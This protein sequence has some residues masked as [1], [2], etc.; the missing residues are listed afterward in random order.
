MA[1]ET[2]TVRT[3]EKKDDIVANVMTEQD[4]HQ[5]QV[6]VERTLEL[7]PLSEIFLLVSTIARA[8]VEIDTFTQFGQAT[9][10]K[11]HNA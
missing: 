3:E 5:E 7:K 8:I 2:E 1:H 4:F 10:A 11:V 6:W 9:R